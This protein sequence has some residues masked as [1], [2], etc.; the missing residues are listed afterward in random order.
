MDKRFLI[1]MGVIIAA[2]AGIMVYS[3]INKEDVGEAGSV[4][5]HTKGNNSKNV[6]LVAY[7][8]FQCPACGSFEPIISEVTNKYSDEMLYTF[9][10]FPIDTIHPNARAAS[11]AAEAAGTQGKFW[12]MHDVLF[13]NQLQWSDSQSAK[14]IFDSYATQLGL[15]MDEYNTVYVATTT[16][17][18]I[19]A[20]KQEGQDLG[21]TGTP[22]FFINGDQIDNT[23]IQTVESF[24]SVIEEYIA[25]SGDQPE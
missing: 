13:A 12:E 17:S 10:H 24:S 5:N 3:N 18:T 6:E 1:I 21:V 25:N 2:F 4:S 19:N 15:N 9:R 7:S 11:R 22:A 23:D 14:T 8:D 16:N 20:D